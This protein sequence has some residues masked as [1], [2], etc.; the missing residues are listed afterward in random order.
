M[1]AQ[2]QRGIWPDRSLECPN[3]LDQVMGLGRCTPLGVYYYWTELCSTEQEM[4]F[5][6]S[7]L[8]ARKL[9][10][11]VKRCHFIRQ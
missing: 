8:A 2:F 7:L 6:L 11:Q 5:N 9:R 4:W 3:G 1:V 10:L